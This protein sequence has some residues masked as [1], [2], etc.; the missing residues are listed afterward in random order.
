M[1]RNPAWC[2]KMSMLRARTC[3]ERGPLLT[4]VSATVH[5]GNVRVG[6]HVF[7]RY[8]AGL[9]HVPCFCCSSAV[10]GDEVL[11]WLCVWGKVQ[12]ICM[13]QLMPL[14]PGHL[15]LQ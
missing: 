12:I 14:P 3:S 9:L 4:S 11:A 7:G 10:I 2:M 13:V 15:L 6:L 5:A 1:L 8:M